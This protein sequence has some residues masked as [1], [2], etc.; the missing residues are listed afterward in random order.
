MLKI[1]QLIAHHIFI[2]A[3]M[4]FFFGKCC[5]KEPEVTN[6]V[7]NES[8]H[9]FLIDIFYKLRVCKCKFKSDIG[10]GSRIQN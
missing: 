1:F 4:L 5:A 7:Y 8:W 2:W 10:S 6:G 9:Y 3:P